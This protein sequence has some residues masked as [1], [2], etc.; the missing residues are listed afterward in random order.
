MELVA[1]VHGQME[2]AEG[3]KLV[4]LRRM[5]AVM[6]VEAVGLKEEQRSEEQGDYD[7]LILFELRLLLC[8]L[9]LLSRWGR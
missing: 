6:G 8:Y 5:Q 9:I 3:Q 1:R 2:V 7:G 4:V